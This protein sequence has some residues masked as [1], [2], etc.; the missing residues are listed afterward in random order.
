M[1]TSK[2]LGLFERT[3]QSLSLINF[4]GCIDRCCIIDDHSS[5]GDLQKMAEILSRLNV[6]T[7]IISSPNDGPRR[8]VHAMNIWLELISA[9]EFVFHC[10]DDWE[11]DTKRTLLPMFR[12]GIGVL[13]DHEWIGQ[14][15]FRKIEHRT[16]SPN[17]Y[18]EFWVRT[19]ANCPE[20]P[21]WASHPGHWPSRFT[22]TPTVTRVASLKGLGSFEEVDHF[23]K[24]FGLKWV[25]A[26]WTTVYHNSA[27]CRHIGEGQSAYQINGSIH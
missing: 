22:L 12:W 2:R 25:E 21:N 9:E 23:E 11:F 20:D 7:T 24:V 5:P 1:T 15:C 19:V 6:P 17:P 10:E 13:R 16:T 18:E 27:W 8:H 4:Q 3:V 14:A 26:G